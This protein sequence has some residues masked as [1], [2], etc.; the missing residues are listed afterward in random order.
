MKNCIREM[1][2][3][4]KAEERPFI[5]DHQMVDV[6]FRAQILLFY[7]HARRKQ[8]SHGFKTPACKGCHTRSLHQDTSWIFSTR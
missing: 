8:H 5:Q 1:G 4:T 2:C 7:K 6:H 3:S